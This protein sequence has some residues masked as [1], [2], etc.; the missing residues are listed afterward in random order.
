MSIKFSPLLLQV[1]PSLPPF[2]LS[3]PSSFPPSLLLKSQSKMSPGFFLHIGELIQPE[4]RHPEPRQEVT[5][6]L[7]GLTQGS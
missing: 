5:H 4:R 1:T 2:S 6:C 3:L 7:M